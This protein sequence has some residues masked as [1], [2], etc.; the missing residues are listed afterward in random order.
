MKNIY[1]QLVIYIEDNKSIRKI[2]YKETIEYLKEVIQMIE[3]EYKEN[4]LIGDEEN[5]R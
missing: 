4:G 2:D 5:D 1:T 3:E